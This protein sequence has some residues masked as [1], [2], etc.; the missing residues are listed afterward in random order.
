MDIII[1]RERTFQN[2]IASG[3]TRELTAKYYLIP[4]KNREFY[5]KFLQAHC[6]Q[7]RVLEYGCGTG[8]YASFLAERGASYFGIDISDVAI[9]KS[10]DDSFIALSNL[11]SFII[12]NGEK[13]GFKDNT[14]DLVCG[15]GILHHLNIEKAFNEICRVLKK[16]GM[17]IFR[18][19]L[20]H[21]PIINLYRKST[22][23]LRTKDEHPLKINDINMARNYFGKIDIHFFNLITLI[24]VIFRKKKYFNKVIFVLD[25]I[26]QVLFNLFPFLKKYAWQTTIIMRK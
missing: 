20:G 22:P 13:L 10:K 7:K 1:K 15:S 19:P 4:I 23:E 2:K 17:A 16:E 9:Q 18:E 12:M 26:D 14:F 8:T 11:Q 5:V 24:A 21:N 6:Y 25:K 3:K